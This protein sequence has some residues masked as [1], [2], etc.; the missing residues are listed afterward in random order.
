[1][2]NFPRANIRHFTN[3]IEH[4]TV[5]QGGQVISSSTSISTN[6]S[7]SVPEPITNA[8]GSQ[9]EAPAMVC[10]TKDCNTPSKESSLQSVEVVVKQE[11]EPFYGKIG[12]S[13]NENENVQVN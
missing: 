9:M 1:M 8:Q 2:A 7:Y 10:P 13:L 11:H 6:P 4:Y 12:S 5:Q 3:P